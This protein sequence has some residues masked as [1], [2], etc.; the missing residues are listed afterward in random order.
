M[1]SNSVERGVGT[2]REL[3]DE[4]ADL[5]RLIVS[6]VF[7]SEDQGRAL[8]AV[9]E[10]AGVT[11]LAA[12]FVRLLARNRRLFALP[13]IIKR[14]ARLMAD[15]RGETLAVVTSAEKLTE[16]QLTALREALAEKAGGSVN[17]QTHVDPSLIGGLVVQLGSQMIDTSV[18][19]RLQSLKTAMKEAA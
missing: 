7:T 3:L 15:H 10:K 2:L 12:N 9:M 6:P 18:K 14:Y 1:R 11:G 13:D 4:S 5:R 16:S 19:T 17:L 8:G